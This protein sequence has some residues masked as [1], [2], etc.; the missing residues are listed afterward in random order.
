MVLLGTYIKWLTGSYLEMIQLN[1]RVVNSA[2]NVCRQNLNP[3]KEKL[4]RHVK[5]Y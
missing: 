2:L 4:N 5:T 1:I 3:M